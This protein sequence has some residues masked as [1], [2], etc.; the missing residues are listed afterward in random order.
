M[1]SHSCGKK[2][3]T[4]QARMAA[5]VPESILDEPVPT[6]SVGE[7][8]EEGQLSSIDRLFQKSSI[9]P[10]VCIGGEFAY[11]GVD[12]DSQL[13][14]D[15]VRPTEKRVSFLCWILILDGA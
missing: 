6:T 3:L 5:V 7:S 9:L 4:S 14:L 12:D 2:R 1:R 11:E 15:W 10:Q 8:V 13:H